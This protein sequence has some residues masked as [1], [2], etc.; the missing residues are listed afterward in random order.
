MF[1]SVFVSFE[2]CSYFHISISG[3]SN[4]VHDWNGLFRVHLAIYR[5]L[6]FEP[7]TLPRCYV[8]FKLCTNLL[9]VTLSFV[10]CADVYS[11]VGP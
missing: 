7:I 10:C 9:V 3:F 2:L 11:M 1:D 6:C 8:Y 5:L 4:A